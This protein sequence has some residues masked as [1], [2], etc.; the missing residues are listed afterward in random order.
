[1][2]GLSSWSMVVANLLHCM[3]V[4]FQ[5]IKFYIFEAEVMGTIFFVQHKL[6][7]NVGRGILKK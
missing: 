3:K 4:V 5:A 6:V 7:V 2:L 1:M